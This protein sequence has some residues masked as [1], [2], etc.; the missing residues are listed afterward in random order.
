MVLVHNMWTMFVVHY[1][2]RLHLYKCTYARS[3]I[4]KHLQETEPAHLKIGKSQLQ[5]HHAVDGNYS[6]GILNRCVGTME[7][8]NRERER[9]ISDEQIGNTPKNEKIVSRRIPVNKRE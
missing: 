2:Q 9:A 7:Q 8:K 4:I 6:K 1:K 5:W 3:T